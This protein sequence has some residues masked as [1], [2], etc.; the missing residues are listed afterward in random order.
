[1]FVSFFLISTASLNASSLAETLVYL[2]NEF[3]FDKDFTIFLP[4][5]NSPNWTAQCNG[6]AV[7]VEM[8]P[9]EVTYLRKY[10]LTNIAQNTTVGEVSLTPNVTACLHIKRRWRVP[11]NEHA[12]MTYWVPILVLGCSLFFMLAGVFIFASDN[13]AEDPRNANIF[14][15]EGQKVVT[16]K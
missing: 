2:A 11:S 4:D 5:E 13:Y 15:T 3:T 14:A 12:I 6:T 9:R 10:I 8:T 1:M 16:G 7:E